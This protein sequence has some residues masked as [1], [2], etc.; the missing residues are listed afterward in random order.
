MFV[1]IKKKELPRFMNFNYE[2]NKLIVLVTQEKEEENKYAFS[3]LDRVG[4]YVMDKEFF[5]EIN[6]IIT[7][8]QI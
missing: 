6:E 7:I 5:E 4:I 8:S 2:G 3:F 1:T